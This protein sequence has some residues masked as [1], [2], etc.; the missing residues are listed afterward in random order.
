MKLTMVLLF[1]CLFNQEI[2]F[3]TNPFFFFFLRNRFENIMDI[4]VLERIK[5]AHT[6]DERNWAPGGQEK[7]REPYHPC[8]HAHLLDQ[9]RLQC[10]S[11]LHHA[12]SSPNPLF[13]YI[14]TV[15]LMTERFSP[16]SIMKKCFC[17][18]QISQRITM[19]NG[20]GIKPHVATIL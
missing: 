5:G 20:L 11:M 17:I 15:L 19:S 3:Q 2:S 16:V 13:S 9:I 18:N 7:T 1:S 4:N 8:Y 12:R 6:S 14:P 10:I